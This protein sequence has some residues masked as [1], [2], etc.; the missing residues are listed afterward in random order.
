MCALKRRLRRSG[1]ASE[2]SK[3]GSGGRPGDTV[4][5]DDPPIIL[6]RLKPGLT[7]ETKRVVH[8]VRVPDSGNVPEELTAY[9]GE[10]FEPGTIEFLPA[11]TGMPCVRCLITAPVPRS[12]ALPP[13][14]DQ[15]D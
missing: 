13:Q 8:L 5:A 9:C 4:P 2:Q 12:P 15:N 11:P 14:S 7:G 3:A 10:R 1:A 6:V